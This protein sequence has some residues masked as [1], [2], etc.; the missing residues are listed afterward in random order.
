MKYKR[1]S[2]EELEALK[3]DFIKFLV[4]NGIEASMWESYKAKEPDMADGLIEKFSDFVWERIIN[5]VSYLETI[6]TQ[7]IKLYHCAEDKLY[8][9]GIYNETEGETID[10]IEQYIAAMRDFPD[11]FKIVKAYRDYKEGDKSR[12]IFTLIDREKAHVSKGDLYKAFS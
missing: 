2:I 9:V 6:D 12:D 1:L 7:G 11:K 5:K 8:M 4:V 10:T 3:D